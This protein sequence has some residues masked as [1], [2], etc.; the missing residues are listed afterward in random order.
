MLIEQL[1]VLLQHL[2]VFHS[3]TGMLKDSV[4]VRV[5]L[6]DFTK[7]FDI[8]DHTV[9]MSKEVELQLPGNI[10]N[11]IGSFLSQRKQFQS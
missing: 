2:H 10:Y 5:I 1:S 3:L 4:Y 9:L 11:W 8:A 7:A 6:N